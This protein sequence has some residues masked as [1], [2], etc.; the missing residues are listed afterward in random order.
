MQIFCDPPAGLLRPAD[1]GWGG[2]G[3]GGGGSSTADARRSKVGSSALFD[4]EN[5]MQS[6]MRAGSK[7]HGGAGG[8]GAGAAGSVGLSAGL[9]GG[10]GG[11][12]GGSSKALRAGPRALT[13]GHKQGLAVLQQGLAT[14]PQNNAEWWGHVTARV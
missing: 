5:L 6:V 12:L 11:G 13:G 8:A 9:G 7:Q 14:K 3:G 2:G 4:Q 1:G 10:G